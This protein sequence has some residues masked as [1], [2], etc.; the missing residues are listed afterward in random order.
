MIIEGPIS[1]MTQEKMLA[2]ANVES[3]VDTRRHKGMEYYFIGHGPE[4]RARESDPFDD[5]E[6]ASYSSFAIK[7]KAIITGSEDAIESTPGQRRQDCR[8]RQS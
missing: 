7:G 8:F 5:L 4:R 6:E 3:T 2:L 1:T